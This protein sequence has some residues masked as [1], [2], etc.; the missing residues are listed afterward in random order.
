M[1]SGLEIGD[2]SVESVRMNLMNRVEFR[3]IRDIV[4]FSLL[5]KGF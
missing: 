4:G 1:R 3:E 5:R 2:A